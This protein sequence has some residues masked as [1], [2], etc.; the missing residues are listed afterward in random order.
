MK[1]YREWERETPDSG[2]RGGESEQGQENRRLFVCCL[3][4]QSCYCVTKLLSFLAVVAI[5]C[6]LSSLSPVKLSSHNAARNSS[7]GYQP[8]R[9]ALHHSA[10]VS[11]VHLSTRRSVLGWFLLRLVVSHRGSDLSSPVPRGSCALCPFP[12]CFPPPRPPLLSSPLFLALSNLLMASLLSLHLF[13][14]HRPVYQSQLLPA[15]C[16]EIAR[17]T[18]QRG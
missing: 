2:S 3:L 10:A 14:V 18:R 13:S 15:Q 6:W 4:V 5:H 9:S 16:Q 11:L 12:I 7:P 1:K 8:K 17:R